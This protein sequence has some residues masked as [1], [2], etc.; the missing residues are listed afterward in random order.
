VIAGAENPFITF[1]EFNVRLWKVGPAA[2]SSGKFSIVNGS[3]G[4]DAV[5]IDGASN[6]GI[7]T[8]TPSHRLSVAGTIRAKEL[9]VDSTGW[10]DAVFRIGHKR[11][12][13][14][15]VESFIESN[16]HLPGIPSEQEV[17][18]NGINVA[19]VQAKLLEKIE[20]LFLHQIEMEKRLRLLEAE[21]AALKEQLISGSN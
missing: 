18:K 7:G 1:N 13:L 5:T 10:A 14:A 9:I 16:G 15:D 2:G 8:T 19:S 6:V 21:N 4:A 11:T 17:A 12:A 3:T 20:E